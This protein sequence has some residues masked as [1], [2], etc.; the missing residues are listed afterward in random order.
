MTTDGSS[1]AVAEVPKKAAYKTCKKKV[2]L[3]V[4]LLS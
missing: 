1:G 3:V 2:L 4:F